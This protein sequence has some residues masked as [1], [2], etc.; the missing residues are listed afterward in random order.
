MTSLVARAL[1]AALAFVLVALPAQAS[2]TLELMPDWVV[3]V[4]LLLV[5]VVI[6]FPLNALIFQPLLRVMDER[7]EK[8]EGARARADR[9]ERQAQEALDRYQESIR[10]AYE[11]V[12]AERRRKLDVARGEMQE[13]TRQAKSDA[14]RDITRAREELGASLEDARESLRASA[15][16]L[17]GLAAERILGRSLSQ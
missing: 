13:V 6:I 11:E 14:A 17:A 15:Q 8:I 5:F 9:V 4:S 3:L 7:D 12:N 2:E 10:T 16:E 1:P